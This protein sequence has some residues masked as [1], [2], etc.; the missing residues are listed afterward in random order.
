MHHLTTSHTYAVGHFIMFNF[1]HYIY[2]RRYERI[3][4]RGIL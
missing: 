4:A 1:H 2:S 3:A